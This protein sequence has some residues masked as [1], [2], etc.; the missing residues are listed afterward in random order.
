MK[1]AMFLMVLMATLAFGFASVKSADAAWGYY[2]LKI[3]KC[4]AWSGNTYMVASGANAASAGI[5]NK[6]IFFS[7]NSA[8]EMLAI[9]LAANSNVVAYFDS[10]VKGPA[11]LTLDLIK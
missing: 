6:V 4:G 3:S 5:T 7:A 8:K 1:K 11:A 10:S 9:C 2:E